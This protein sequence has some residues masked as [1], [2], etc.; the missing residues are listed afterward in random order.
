MSGIAG[1]LFEIEATKEKEPPAIVLRL[2]L[3][4]GAGA[5]KIVGRDG[6]AIAVQLAVPHVAPRATAECVTLIAETLGVDET[7]VE[8][9]AGEKMRERRFR[10]VGVDGDAARLK[11]DAALAGASGS[12]RDRRG[13]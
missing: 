13:R 3:R 11:I 7:A 8:L 2:R 5:T 6:N 9:I 10:V 4:A 1:D 12:G